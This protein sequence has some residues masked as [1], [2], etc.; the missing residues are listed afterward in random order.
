MWKINLEYLNFC[1]TG[2]FMLTYFMC[3]FLVYEVGIFINHM[4]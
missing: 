2:I 1:Y 3:W 4:L